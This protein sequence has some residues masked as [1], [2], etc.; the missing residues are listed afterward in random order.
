V[1]IEDLV[2]IDLAVAAG[3]AYLLELGAEVPDLTP[4]LASVREHLTEQM[5]IF[6]CIQ[7]CFADVSSDVQIEKVG[8]ARHVVATAE[9]GESGTK[10]LADNFAC[11]IS[12]VGE[13]QRSAERQRAQSRVGARVD[14]LG[15]AFL[16]DHPTSATRAEVR[17]LLED[18]EAGLDQTLEADYVYVEIRRIREEFKLGEDLAQS[19]S[20]YSALRTQLGGLQY[21]GVLASQPE[22]LP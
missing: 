1:D 15:A 18:I 3:K 14:R 8:F 12:R 2:P 22:S 10:S 6:A 17:V 4:I 21:R 9:K 13:L 5:G 7:K 20:E 19:V 16:K 11:L